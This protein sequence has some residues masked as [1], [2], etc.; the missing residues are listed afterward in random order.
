MTNKEIL[1]GEESPVPKRNS[2]RTVVTSTI[3]TAGAFVSSL[4]LPLVASANAPISYIENS[5]DRFIDTINARYGKSLDTV[6][7]LTG[8]DRDMIVSVIAIESE[9]VANAT[10]PVGAK[11]LMQLMPETA[12]E[13]G[14]KDRTDP[15]QNMLGGSRYIQALQKEYGFDNI[16]QALIAYN[17]GPSRAKRFLSQYDEQDNAYVKRIRIVHA[18][19]QERRKEEARVAVIEAANNIAVSTVAVRPSVLGDMLS[20][21]SLKPKLAEASTSK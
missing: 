8:L 21:I 9:G 2:F 14:V 11:G 15:F 20:A 17:M 7:M 16:D 1:M 18:R 12:R 19:I 6:S 10:S 13:L 3:M 5:A 4:A